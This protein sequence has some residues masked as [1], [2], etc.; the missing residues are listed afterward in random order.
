MSGCVHRWRIAE[1]D[2]RREL[3]AECRH[4]GATTA[5]VA[6]TDHYESDWATQSERHHASFLARDRV[7]HV[8]GTVWA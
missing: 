6:A 2:G 4:C 5:F 7:G 1:P 8:R 3:P